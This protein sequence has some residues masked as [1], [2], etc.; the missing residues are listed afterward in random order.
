MFA[1]NIEKQ[2]QIAVMKIAAMNTA[3]AM[4]LVQS[5]LNALKRDVSVN[6]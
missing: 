1:M 6:V 5:A 2:E 4:T 3:H